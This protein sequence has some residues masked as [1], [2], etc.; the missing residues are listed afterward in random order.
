MRYYVKDHTLVVKGDFDGIS[1]GIN[2]GRRRVRSVVNH[3]V[4]R[5]FNNDDPATYLDEVAV[6]AGAD[7]PYFGF[8]TA[9]QMKNLCVVGT[10]MSPLLSPQ[11]SATPATTRGCPGR[12][13]CCW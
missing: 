8:L 13:T 7:T 9:V 12:S 2:G 4:S 1:T 11:A 6:S 5:Q 3:E 10:R